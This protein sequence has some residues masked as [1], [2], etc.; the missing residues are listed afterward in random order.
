MRRLAAASLEVTG[1]CC[2]VAALVIMVC[3]AGPFGGLA[4]WCRNTADRL[5]P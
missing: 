5:S 1:Y 3:V 4:I 2:A